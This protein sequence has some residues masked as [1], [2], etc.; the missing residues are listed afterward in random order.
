VT[1]ALDDLSAVPHDDVLDVVEARL[2]LGI[3]RGRAQYSRFN[4]TAGFPSDAGTWIRLAWHRPARID[5]QSWTGYEAALAI[6]DV[7]RPIWRTA[8]SWHDPVRDVVWR[9]EELT[10]AP[11]PAISPTATVAL[12]PLLPDAWWSELTTALTALNEH[13]T[14]RVCM[15]Q[16]HLSTRIGEATSP[17]RT[18]PS[19]TG[20]AGAPAPRP[21]T[22]P[23]FGLPRSRCR[24]WPRE[25]TRSSETSCRPALGAS[26]S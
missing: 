25:S 14:N 11:S 20:K 12:A 17:D 6:K 15:A 8:A 16:T 1:L 3:D 23:T 18:C 7:P 13:E 19:W 21:S 9:A 2:G 26:A 10:M 22:P 24:P 5:T 4:G